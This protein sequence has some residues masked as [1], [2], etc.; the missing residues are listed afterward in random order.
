MDANRSNAERGGVRVTRYIARGD[1]EAHGTIYQQSA[2]FPI[3][4]AAKYMTSNPHPPQPE[5]SLANLPPRLAKRIRMQ[6]ILLNAF[7]FL[8]VSSSTCAF[9]FVYRANVPHEPF[10]PFI[11]GFLSSGLITLLCALVAFN[12]ILTKLLHW[13][14]RQKCPSCQTPLVLSMRRTFR[15]HFFGGWSCNSC[16]AQF[17]RSSS[18]THGSPRP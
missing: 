15:Q 10:H 12:M 17:P 18:K 3:F 5:L 1:R 11:I 16:G 14:L 7:T 9:A 2:F 6:R 8:L 4:A 13:T